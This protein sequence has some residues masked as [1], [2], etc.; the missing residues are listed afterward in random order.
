MWA[1]REWAWRIWYLRCRLRLRLCWPDL[2]SFEG[3]EELW[4]W[5]MGMNVTNT[6]EGLNARLEYSSATNM[7]SCV[8]NISQR[9]EAFTR[10]HVA[11]S[12][13]ASAHEY[14]HG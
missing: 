1:V 4:L 10:Q 7:E 11:R 2:G 13:R 3:K 9:I 6:R 12:T 8:N 14:L 5:F